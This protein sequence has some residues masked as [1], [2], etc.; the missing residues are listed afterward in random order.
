M[1]EKDKGPFIEAKVATTNIIAKNISKIFKTK[2]QDIL[3]MDN[4]NIE[5]LENE[6][7]SIVGT[8]GCGKSTLLRMLGGLDFPTKGEIII[9]DKKVV[10]PGVDRGMVFQGYTLFPW[11]SVEDNIRYGLK[12]KKMP[13]N[14]QDE[15]VDRYL[16]IIGLK[17]FRKAYPN[18]LSGGMKQRVAIARA[19]ANNPELLLMD[20]PFGA[21]DPITKSSMQ[22]FIRKIWQ[23]D[24]PTIAFVTHDIDEAVFLSTK[25]YVMSA[26]PGRV[27]EIIPVY[28]PYNRTL[29]TKDTPEFLEIRDRIGELLNSN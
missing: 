25:I 3:A 28:L 8:S 29:D 10:G 9:K 14:E 7:V 17:R 21:L 11:M 15:V 16:G 5:I 27:K 24:K 12:Q 2:K 6:F 26:R 20:E 13:K 18:Q 23:K 4:C 19:L 1:I 22:L